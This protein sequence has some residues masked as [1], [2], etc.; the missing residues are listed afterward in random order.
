MGAPMGLNPKILLHAIMK[1][2]W[3]FV[4]Q[5]KIMEAEEPTV[6]VGAIPSELTA[7]PPP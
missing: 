6:R 5:G 2:F 1:I 7:P 3:I 4:E